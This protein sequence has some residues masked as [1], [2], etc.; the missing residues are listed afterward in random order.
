MD[1]PLIQFKALLKQEGLNLV[2]VIPI[3]A[4][5]QSWNG[6]GT[7][8]YPDS[9]SFLL[10]G[11]G[12][13]DHWDFVQRQSLK[14]KHPI[15][16][17]AWASVRK[18]LPS[19]VPGAQL[20]SQKESYS[21]DLRGLAVLAGF[22]TL[23]PYLLLVLHPTYG[24]WISLRAIV[25]CPVALKPTIAIPEYQPCE[26]CERPC[27]TA[28]PVS[29][30]SIDKPWDVHKCAGH[31][32]EEEAPEDHCASQCHVR[33]ACPVGRE[34]AYSEAE[35]RHRHRSSLPMIRAFLESESGLE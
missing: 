16:E 26:D 1:T 15:E 8:D 11:S 19:F 25:Y 32:L 33:L 3:Q 13:R 12:G 29:A 30:Y 21:F 34:H 17:T 24:P 7:Y 6:L 28:C 5:K 35:F 9:G 10:I 2:G 4:A 14:S 20:L 22:G 31:R 23:S 18:A 27:L